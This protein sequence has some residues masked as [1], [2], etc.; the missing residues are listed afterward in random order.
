MLTHAET[1]VQP[2]HQSVGQLGT[3]HVLIV[4]HGVGRGPKVHCR[5]MRPAHCQPM[6]DTI[7]RR[8]PDLARRFRFWETGGPQPAVDNV[9]AV[10]FLLQDPLRETHPACF[11]EA[12]ELANRARASGARIVNAP[13]SLSNT[14]KS[15]QFRLWHDAGLPTPRCVAFESIDQLHAAAAEI[16]APMILKADRQ[17]AQKHTLLVPDQ[18]SLRRIPSESIPIP[19]SLS[20]AVDT[21]SGYAEI[22]PQSPYATHYH[23]KR[24]MVF[25]K[26][27]R[28]N[29]VFFS[30]QPIVGCLSSTFNHFRSPNLIR[31]VI[32][33][34]RCRSH[35]DHD[36]CYHHSPCDDPETLVRAASVLGVEFCA[37]DYSS[38]ADGRI[39]LW[40]ANPYFSLH[41]WPVAVLSRQRRLRERIQNIHETAA[42]FFRDLLGEAP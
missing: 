14:I 35:V 36:L 7:A 38:H 34:V 1:A 20:P 10:V 13:E 3:S 6:F 9:A 16:D 42:Q 19:G 5:S 17:H 28:N 32:G 11:E 21:R 30:D 22:D 29:H 15:K 39:V 33:N 41:R 31:R 18:E 25:G 27:V 2:S 26:H 8:W 12:V 4:R 40:E 37:I 24:V 23:K